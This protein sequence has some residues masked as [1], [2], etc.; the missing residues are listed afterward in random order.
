VRND[1]Q[2]VLPHG[3]TNSTRLTAEGHVEKVYLGMRRNERAACELACLTHLAT[4]LPVPRV[5]AFERDGTSMTTA[6]LPGHHGQDLLDEGHGRSVLELVGRTHR[7]LQQIPVEV[8]P[9]LPGHGA[10]LVHGDFGAQNMLFDLDHNEVT[11]ILDWELAQ[12]GDPIQDLAWAEWIVRT[13]HPTAIRDLDALFDGAGWEPPW[14]DRR[15]SMLRSCD[16]HLA[17]CISAGDSGAVELWQ[18]RRRSTADW[19]ELPNTSV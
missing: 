7:R 9:E 15:A 8:L 18:T 12:R 17:T 16:R 13:H 6:K 10:A 1:E 2:M 19:T 11:A 5:I 3:Y 14:E 4:L